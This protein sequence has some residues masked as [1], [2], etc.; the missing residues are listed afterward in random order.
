MR[1]TRTPI[2]HSQ[3]SARV[4][5]E[6]SIARRVIDAPQHR[7][8]INGLPVIRASF[9]RLLYIHGCKT[10]IR[11]AIKDRNA[12]ITRTFGTAHRIRRDTQKTHTRKA[13]G[14]A[15]TLFLRSDAITTSVRMI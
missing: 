9:L 2:A 7:S 11:S 4:A 6:Y 13:G 3:K 5:I 10:L 14:I 8:A 1:D 15:G 12:Y